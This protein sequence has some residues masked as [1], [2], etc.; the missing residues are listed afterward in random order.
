[1]PD[2]KYSDEQ[3]LKMLQRCAEKS[4]ICSPRRFREI[5]ETCSPSLVMRRFGS[6]SDAKERAGITDEPNVGGRKRQY[7]DEDVLNHLRECADR[8]G[9]KCTVE[10][11][12]QEDDLIAPSV[13]VERF[14]SWQAA[15]RIA[16]LDVDE[17]STNH[18]PREY[19]DEDYLEL[20]RECEEKHGKVTQKLFNEE[21]EQRKDHPTAGAVRKRF[22]SWSEAKSQAGISADQRRYT[23]EE[24][25]EMLRECRDRYGRAS[26]STFASDEEFC[27]P[28]TLQRRF[29]SWKDAKERL[30]DENSD[31]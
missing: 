26:A 30:D 8:N 15:K 7:S 3:I 24:L 25:L 31:N 16:G 19:S 13:A 21:A 6:W 11:M 10:L 5:E 27:A 2:R 20:I 23:D 28:E 22:G 9:G 12:Q 1:M 18:R 17:R 14:D 29:G 4:E